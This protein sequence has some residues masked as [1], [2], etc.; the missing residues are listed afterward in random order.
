M[1]KNYFTINI[2][3]DFQTFGD[4]IND[5][6]KSIQNTLDSFA[7]KGGEIFF[8]KGVYLCSHCIFFYSNQKL[9][10][11]EGAILLRANKNQKYL[12]ANKLDE[13]SKKYLATK[14]VEI[15]GTTFDGNAHY[16]TNT[17]SNGKCTLLSTMHSS[18]VKISNCKFINGHTWH[19]YEINASKNITVSNCTFDG[20]NYGGS[21]HKYSELIQLDV[22]F[23]NSN[24]ATATGLQANDG[25]TCE[26]IDIYNCEFICNGVNSA[27]GNHNPTE[28][29]HKNIKIHSCKFKGGSGKRGYITF[30]K[31]THYIDIFDNE[32]IGP[33]NRGISINSKIS[34][35]KIYNNKFINI[36]KAYFGDI[37]EFNNL[38]E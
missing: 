17:R 38:T 25:T 19:F 4:G 2:K 16:S 26:N 15:I 29:N 37:H 3:K 33:S 31:S 20:K 21:T 7:E 12:L 14:N 11:E 23:N 35:C 36:K 6:S 24:S 18:D 27:I 10:F 30:D 32:F 1:Q 28:F 8:P 34:H 5:D 22:D 9:V 13:T